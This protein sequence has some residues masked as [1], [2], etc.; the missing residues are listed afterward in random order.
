MEKNV[1]LS[2]LVRGTMFLLRLFPARTKSAFLFVFLRQK[3]KH[4]LEKNNNNFKNLTT[5][6]VERV[7]LLTDRL[8]GGERGSLIAPCGT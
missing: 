5:E 2:S 4:R 6:T 7:F 8:L 1:I 3:Y